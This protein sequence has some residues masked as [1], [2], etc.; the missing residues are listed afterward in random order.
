MSTRLALLYLAA[1]AL[2]A[3]DGSTPGPGPPPGPLRERD[4]LPAPGRRALQRLLWLDGPAWLRI[5][6]R[7]NGTCTLV[8]TLE[9]AE[10]RTFA[11]LELAGGRVSEVLALPGSGPRPLELHVRGPDDVEWLGLALLQPEPVAPRTGELAGSLAG[12]SVVVFVADSLHSAHLSSYGYERETSPFL[13]RLAERGVRFANAYSQTAWTLSSVSSLFTSVEQERHGVLHIDEQLSDS[14]TTLAQLFAAKGYRTAAVVQNG[15]IYPHTQLD[16]GFEHYDVYGFNPEGTRA[17]LDRSREHLAQS[18]RPLFLYV[19]LT[20]PH[21]P[22]KPPAPFDARFVDPEYAGEVDGT[23]A[24]CAALSQSGLAPGHP[25]VE[26]LEGLYDGNVAFAD[27]EIG[28]LVEELW[29][30]GRLAEFAIV[31]TSDH[32]EAF[33]QHGVQGH[34]A[35]VYEEMVRV[36]LVLAAPGSALPAGAVVGDPVWLL[37]LMPTLIELLGLGAPA[38]G[39]RG[40]SLAPL[41]REPAAS[42]QRPLFL[43][44]RYYADKESRLQLAVRRGRWKLVRRVDELALYDLE[45]DPAE[46]RDLRAEF[47]L[48][49]AVLARQL[50]EWYE[51][52]LREGVEAARVELSQEALEQLKQLGY[53]GEEDG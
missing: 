16:R 13:D 30:A 35:H 36:P 38:H 5:G 7:G 53:V 14:F 49:A 6:A 29:R 4:L 51:E 19:H 25:D 15:I 32:G 50:A 39:M 23:I 3:C 42:F 47:P 45:S 11:E 33:M 41:V 43:S 18:D 22:Y 27:S 37:D 17:L 44:S 21:M 2:A 8:A 9:G 10:P 46:A 34:N 40:R 24:S 31:A 20:P 52:A 48:H 28:T 12:R 26:H 1:L